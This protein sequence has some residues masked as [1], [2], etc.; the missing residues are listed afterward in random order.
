[1][2][3][4]H[5]PENCLCIWHAL[6]MFCLFFGFSKFIGSFIPPLRRNTYGITSVSP[7]QNISIRMALLPTEISGTHPHITTFFPFFY[8]FRNLPQP[9]EL[10]L[11]ILKLMSSNTND[12]IGDMD[13]CHFTHDTST[14]PT[15]PLIQKEFEKKIGNSMG[16]LPRA[17]R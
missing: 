8:S 5:H 6:A 3:N 16:G 9:Q 13:L 12:D 15:P 4:L 10:L 2:Q 14:T 1:M 7:N 11:K 17:L